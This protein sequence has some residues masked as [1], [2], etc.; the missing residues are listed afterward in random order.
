MRT[1]APREYAKPHS[2]VVVAEDGAQDS[3]KRNFP[4]GV[5]AAQGCV[6]LCPG[7]LRPQNKYGMSPQ[8]INSIPRLP[9]IKGVILIL[10]QIQGFCVKHNEKCLH[11]LLKY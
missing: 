5:F 9:E 3:E 7:D 10:K 11:E 6:A 8:S 4:T 2:S 1:G